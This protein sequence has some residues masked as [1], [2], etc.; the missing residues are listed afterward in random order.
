MSTASFFFQLTTTTI[1]YL[2]V[3]GAAVTTRKNFGWLKFFETNYV[4]VTFEPFFVGDY[5]QL[6]SFRKI[7]F[8]KCSTDPVH[9]PRFIML[10]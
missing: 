6:C 8:E 1:K 2:A 9:K 10:V 3:P 5:N 7:N 4:K